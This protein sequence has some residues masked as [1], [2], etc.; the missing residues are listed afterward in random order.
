MLAK[1]VRASGFAVG[2]IAATIV[3]RE[4]W[5]KMPA[6]ELLMIGFA[7]LFAFVTI[8]CIVE[9]ALALES[10][11]SIGNGL[12]AQIFND[13]MVQRDETRM[14]KPLG[15]SKENRQAKGE[16]TERRN[17]KQE[18]IAYFKEESTSEGGMDKRI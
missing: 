12:Q 14:N 2:I 4:K 15:I 18:R 6:P 13:S 17:K 10:G 7:A 11:N 3:A 5:N 1:Q 9:P 16:C 8:Y